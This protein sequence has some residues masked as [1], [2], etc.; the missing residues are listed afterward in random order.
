ML[1]SEIWFTNDRFKMVEL[2]FNVFNLLHQKVHLV[3]LISLNDLWFRHGFLGL[4]LFFGRSGKFQQR[5]ISCVFIFMSDGILDLNGV[6][7]A[8]KLRL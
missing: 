2:T 7:A 8:E 6:E 5:L 4:E 1:S 3:H